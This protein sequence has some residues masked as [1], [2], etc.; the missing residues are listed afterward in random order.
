MIDQNTILEI[1][2]E[3]G[4]DVDGDDVMQVAGSICINPELVRFAILLQQRMMGEPVA[5]VEVFNHLFDGKHINL[6]PLPNF[7]S[8]FIRKK[9]GSY[10]LYATPQV[11][12]E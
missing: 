3:A 8:H 7:Q 6:S 5:V 9:D 1:A 10:P 12:E 2:R 11:K 4:F